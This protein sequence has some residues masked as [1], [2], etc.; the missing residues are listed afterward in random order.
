MNGALLVP[1]KD[2]VDA[3]SRPPQLVIDVE[4]GAAGVAEYRIDPFSD[5]RFTQNTGSPHHVRYAFKSKIVVR[6]FRGLFAALFIDH[7]CIFVSIANDPIPKS[8][9]AI[10]L[11]LRMMAFRIPTGYA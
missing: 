7:H 11:P 9:K 3:V 8:R 2:V 4:N 10:I 5:E 6:P 1:N